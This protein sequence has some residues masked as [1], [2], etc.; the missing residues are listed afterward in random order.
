ME[1]VKIYVHDNHV[2]LNAENKLE[3]IMEEYI[4]Q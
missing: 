3:Y 2:K 4:E 1:R